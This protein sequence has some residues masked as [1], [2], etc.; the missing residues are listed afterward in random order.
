MIVYMNGWH[1]AITDGGMHRM[2]AYWLDY[3]RSI[4]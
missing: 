4:L 1:Y 2:Y 3:E